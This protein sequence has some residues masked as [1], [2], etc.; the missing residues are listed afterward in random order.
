[1][2]CSSDSGVRRR[3]ELA[4]DVIVTARCFGEIGIWR[5]PADL[6]HTREN[7]MVGLG[8]S[9]LSSTRYQHVPSRAASANT[10]GSGLTITTLEYESGKAMVGSR[11]RKPATSFRFRSA[12]AWKRGFIR[13]G[14]SEGR[15]PLRSW[16]SGEVGVSGIGV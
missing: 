7:H 3:K 1:M 15:A 8:I 13:A 2:N 4:N 10:C 5:L 9:D 16:H 12:S 11:R 14:V 6:R